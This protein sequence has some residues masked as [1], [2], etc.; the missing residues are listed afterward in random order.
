MVISMHRQHLMKGR[1][2]SWPWF[3]TEKL[4]SE[5]TETQ[6]LYLTL[7]FCY[8]NLTIEGNQDMNVVLC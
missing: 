4:C 2:I 3:N 7:T 6:H 1:E 5:N 8:L